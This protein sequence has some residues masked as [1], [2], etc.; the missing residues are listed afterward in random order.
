MS[1]ATKMTPL[2]RAKVGAM[3]AIIA[4]I[5]TTIPT[6][7]AAT[8]DASLAKAAAAAKVTAA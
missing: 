7:A 2:N 6:V 8:A 4:A 3:T 5:S 1:A